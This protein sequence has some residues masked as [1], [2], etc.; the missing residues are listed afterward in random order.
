MPNNM[1]VVSLLTSYDLRA[2]AGTQL[3]EADYAIL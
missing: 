1:N 2:I 3:K